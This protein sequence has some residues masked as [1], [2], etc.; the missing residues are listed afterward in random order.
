[1]KLFRK[2]SISNQFIILALLT[3][4][5]IVIFSTLFLNR[6]TNMLYQQ[7]EQ[8]RIELA[9]QIDTSI[10]SNA[11]ELERILI[12]FSLEKDIEDYLNADTFLEKA[13][14]NKVLDKRFL[15][16]QVLKDDITDFVILGKNGQE[17]Y[18]KGRRAELTDAIKSLE[19]PKT[20]KHLFYS[21]C[22]TTYDDGYPQ[23]FFLVAAPY[24][25]SQWDKSN[26]NNAVMILAVKASFFSTIP[27]KP[28]GKKN[29]VE[30]Y[31]YDKSGR[32]YNHFSEYSKSNM[33]DVL[34]PNL[35]E[36]EKI[37]KQNKFQIFIRDIPS[38]E[39]S[40][41][42]LTKT[43]VLFGN[44][45]EIRNSIILSYFIVAII[46]GILFFSA[47][48]AITKPLKRLT[49][50]IVLLRS[51]PTSGLLPEELSDGS[52]EI[53][54]L[55][56]EFNKLLKELD[57]AA[58]SLLQHSAILYEQQLENKQTE[59]LQLRSQINPH[60]LY[61]TLETCKGVAISEDAY[62]VFGML[63]ALGEMFRYSVTGD[64]TVYLEEE[65]RIVR[66]YEK[67]QKVRFGQRVEMVYHIPTELLGI[68]IPKMLLQ[69]LVENAV[70]HGVEGLTGNGLIEIS[71]FTDQHNILYI[72][73]V[74]NGMGCSAEELARI[75]NTL[76]K[77]S[78][79]SSIGLLNV[80]R[81]I[82]LQYGNDY[83]VNIQSELGRGTQVTVTIPV[84][85]GFSI[86]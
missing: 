24:R 57:E 39:G 42:Y 49:S 55:S 22:F 38:I 75:R 43:E 71:A 69:P 36:A 74:D 76:A 65:I 73:V 9:D 66:S 48:Q 40:I 23:S 34:L 64:S 84:D 10:S 35:A 67:L 70:F 53:V 45:V 26:P 86:E 5:S 16:M 18:S 68:K 33:E 6:I 8:Y 30:I 51:K 46:I 80:H 27:A 41:A 56:H 47:N 4:L 29:M 11:E 85:G 63:D 61:N 21:Q 58:Q 62:Q 3:G 7:N 1:M 14:A 15:Q 31:F 79:T 2:A 77:S 20:F 44:L 28:E 25:R 82:T 19:F 32:L 59:I 78:E 37:Q 83:G 60:F 81:R 50:Q 54:V 72:M 52:E 17:Y 13:E 12:S